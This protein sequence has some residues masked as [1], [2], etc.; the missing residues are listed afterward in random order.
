MQYGNP[1]HATQIKLVR[2]HFLK[3]SQNISIGATDALPS[4]PCPPPE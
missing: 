3:M 1:S 4:V 2:Q